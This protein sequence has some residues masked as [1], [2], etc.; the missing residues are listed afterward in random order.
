[1]DREIDQ[2]KRWKARKQESNSQEPAVG[3]MPGCLAREGNTSHRA[4]LEEAIGGEDADVGEEGTQRNNH[5]LVD[6]GRL[7]PRR[8]WPACAR[9]GVR[10]QRRR[11]RQHPPLQ[12]NPPCTSGL[13]MR[14]LQINTLHNRDG[15]R[16]S[17]H[18]H[19]QKI[20]PLL[21]GQHIPSNCMPMT[22]SS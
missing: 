1:M 2:V 19:S 9:L 21:W 14:R 6:G 16:H 8:H 12:Q 11:V 10:R 4:I 15:T 22:F 18:T 3:S 20:I 7:Q 13:L 17:M 5:A